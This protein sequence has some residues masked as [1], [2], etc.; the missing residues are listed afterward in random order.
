MS[1]DKTSFPYLLVASLCL[2]TLMIGAVAGMWISSSKA[3]NTPQGREHRAEFVGGPLEERIARTAMNDLPDAERQE[4]RRKLRREWRE[5]GSLRAEMTAIRGKMETA[6][7]A[8]DYDPAS[9]KSAFA[10]LRDRE[11]EMKVR[12]HDNLADM[13]TSIPDDKRKT[14]IERSMSRR[15]QFRERLDERRGNG[16]P[17][18]GPDYERRPPSGDDFRRDGPPS[19]PPLED[20]DPEDN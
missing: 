13:L 4:F 12:L 19:Q 7:S 1:T 9:L 16:P 18:G 6:L 3:P 14:L 17:R 11:N 10:E 15:D 8:D 2:N 5:S 20:S